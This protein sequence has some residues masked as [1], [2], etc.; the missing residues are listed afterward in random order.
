MHVPYCLTFTIVAY[1]NCF[2]KPQ[3]TKSVLALITKTQ[4]LCYPSFR[5]SQIVT[6]NVCPVFKTQLSRTGTAQ[7]GGELGACLM[8]YT[9]KNTAIFGILRRNKR[10][11]KMYYFTVVTY[12]KVLAST[13][14]ENFSHNDYRIVNNTRLYDSFSFVHLLQHLH[15]S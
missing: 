6:Q 1:F 13:L 9:L 14:I 4:I 2:S 7:G 11:I 3:F 15:D 5:V 10:N 8:P 12:M